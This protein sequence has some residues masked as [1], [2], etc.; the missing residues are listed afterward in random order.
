MDA[1]TYKVGRISPSKLGWDDFYWYVPP[2]HCQCT[3]LSTKVVS[4]L[5]LHPAQ[6]FGLGSP[7]ILLVSSGA[8]SARIVQPFPK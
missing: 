3:S 6:V 1:I 4:E 5:Q 8:L 2:P 7:I